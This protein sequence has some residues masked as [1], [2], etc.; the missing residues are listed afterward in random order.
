MIDRSLLVLVIATAACGK[1]GQ[2]AAPSS[3]GN[4]LDLASVNALVPAPLKDKLL[5]EKRDVV[6]ERGRHNTTYTLAAPRGWKQ[7]MKSFGSLEPDTKDLGFFTKLEVGSN[8]DGECKAKDW[9]KV[10]DQVSFSA[11]AA[12]GKILKDDKATGHRTMIAESPDGETRTVIVAWW[13]DGASHY[14]TCTATLGNEVKDAAPA[15]EK[16]CQA[17]TVAGD[18]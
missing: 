18:D 16:A 4:A 3:G 17:V 13:T 12:G 9:D 1:G 8:C 6:L 2:K 15:F 7:G 10:A 5:F 11:A 14:N